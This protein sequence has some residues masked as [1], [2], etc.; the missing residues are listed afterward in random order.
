MY[1]LWTPWRL[2]YVT[3]ASAPAT[4]CIFCAALF[5]DISFFRYQGTN[6]IMQLYSEGLIQEADEKGFLRYNLLMNVARVGAA[7]ASIPWWNQLGLI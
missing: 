6:G 5:S 4:D 1:R 2:S 7:Y 3:E